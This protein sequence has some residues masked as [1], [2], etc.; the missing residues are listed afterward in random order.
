MG[1]RKML[2]NFAS[3]P[4]KPMKKLIL[5]VALMINGSISAQTWRADNG[6]GTFTNPLF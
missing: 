6:D 2:K 1:E 4:A 5:I 3:I